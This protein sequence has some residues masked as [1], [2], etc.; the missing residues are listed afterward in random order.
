MNKNIKNSSRLPSV[1]L[2]ILNGCNKCKK[3]KES[4]EIENISTHSIDCDNDPSICDD[5]ENQTNTS[6]YPMALTEHGSLEMIHY[7]AESYEDLKNKDV[8]K[9]NYI[10]KPYASLELMIENLKTKK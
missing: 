10:L 9:N 7:I 2:L 6:T 1:L 4:L 5:L 8:I 3:L